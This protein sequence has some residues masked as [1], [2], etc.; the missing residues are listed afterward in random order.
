MSSSVE[1]TFEN[2]PGANHEI[3]SARMDTDTEKTVIRQNEL[4]DAP[5]LDTGTDRHFSNL[6]FRQ[7]ASQLLGQQ[8]D[9]F[10]IESLVGT[11][12]MGA[13]YS[14]RDLKLDRE[15][16]IKRIAHRTRIQNMPLARLSIQQ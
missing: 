16:A 3:G 8:L 5:S 15:V 2:T 14:G 4:M 1:S 10:R 12:G 9:H 7:S 11:G 6:A 13:V